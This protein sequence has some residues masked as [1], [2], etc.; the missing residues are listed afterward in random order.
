MLAFVLLFMLCFFVLYDG[1]A[2]C[3]VHFGLGG[4]DVSIVA[5]SV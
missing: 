3:V 2:F 4:L 5:P 1:C